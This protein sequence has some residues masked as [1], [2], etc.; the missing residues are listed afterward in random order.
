M[1][2]I[3]ENSLK[4]NSYYVQEKI[5]KDI[6]PQPHKIVKKFIVSYEKIV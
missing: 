4:I 3:K 1:D 6:V 5:K 2:L